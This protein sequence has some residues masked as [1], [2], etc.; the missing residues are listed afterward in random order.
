MHKISAKAVHK[1]SE[2]EAKYLAWLRDNGATFPKIKYPAFN[3]VGAVRGTVA[4]A[5]IAPEEKMLCIP[6]KLL[7]S[8][9]NALKT[10]IAH[11]FK[12]PR[13][14]PRRSFGAEEITVMLMHEK[15]LGKAS[16]YHPYIDVL[17][18]PGTVEK[19]SA[20]DLA[21]FQDSRFTPTIMRLREQKHRAAYQRLIGRL[22][23]LFPDVFSF[24]QHTL[25][26]FLFATRTVQARAFGRRL[27]WMA[28]VPLAD[29]LNHAN[30]ST[31]YDMDVGGNDMFRLFPTNGN[32]YKKGDEVF[33]S[34]GRRDNHHL[35]LYYGFALTNNEWDVFDLDFDVK[36]FMSCYANTH[37]HLPRETARTHRLALF[38]YVAS[39]DRISLRFRFGQLLWEL[40]IMGRIASLP[41][42]AAKDLLLVLKRR[43]RRNSFDDDDAS[44][45][46]QKIEAPIHGATPS[47]CS[48]ATLAKLPKIPDAMT[49]IE[50][51]LSLA[52]ET[53]AIESCI[54]LLSARLSGSARTSLSHDSALLQDGTLS[55]NLCTAINFRLYRK[56][57]L[58]RNLVWL[59]IL[60]DTM[61]GSDMAKTLLMRRKGAVNDCCSVLADA[62]ELAGK[63]GSSNVHKP[64]VFPASAETLSTAAAPVAWVAHN[65]DSDTCVNWVQH[66]T[67]L[68]RATTSVDPAAV[69]TSADTGTSACSAF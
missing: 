58:M 24:E 49:R 5:D 13:S 68:N 22:T 44:S 56:R 1:I 61:K 57:L 64:V 46:T 43:E 20:K 34:Y 27:S 19:W 14:F 21:E 10:T 16:F 65:P 25:E 52:V 66:I 28:L 35:L 11:V 2:K 62:I 31:K 40:L 48:D 37:T 45:E 8:P 18:N 59:R 69:R 23:S 32:C 12:D 42:V 36:E 29:N 55:Y 51:P 6:S 67:Y 15:L 9:P 3:T 17:P 30:V 63:G 41:E 26:L 38:G 4:V 33:N 53:L 50:M 60:R 54:N 47:I 7:I 39:T